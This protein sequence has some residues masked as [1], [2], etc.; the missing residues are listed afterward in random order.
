M[1]G[2]KRRCRWLVAGGLG[3]HRATDVSLYKQPPV[4][5]CRFACTRHTTIYIPLH[6]MK[7][8]RNAVAQNND[9]SFT[10]AV[11]DWQSRV[12]HTSVQESYPAVQTGEALG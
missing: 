3:I 8:S 10:A 1:H 4:V 9:P 11:A 7:S 2:T 12:V 6:A 5:S